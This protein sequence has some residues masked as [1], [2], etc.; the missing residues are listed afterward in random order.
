MPK[1]KTVD[2]HHSAVI[3]YDDELKKILEAFISDLEKRQ[4]FFMGL[5][6]ERSVAQI[7][8]RNIISD[9]ERIIQSTRQYLK[10]YAH[11][12]ELGQA[13]QDEMRDV[14]DITP[15]VSLLAIDKRAL[16]L[17][18]RFDIRK[19]AYF[20]SMG[21]DAAGNG[22]AYARHIT[23]ELLR[24]GNPYRPCFSQSHV[25]P[26]FSETKNTFTSS[27]TILGQDI[28][29]VARTVA[30]NPLQR[31]YLN[32]GV[33][34]YKRTWIAINNRSLT[35][36]SL[37]GIEPRLEVVFP[38]PEVIGYYE[39]KKADHGPD[40]GFNIRF[41]GSSRSAVRREKRSP[42]VIVPSVWA[43]LELA[44]AH[45]L[46]E[47]GKPVPLTSPEADPR[48]R[49]DSRSTV[50]SSASSFGGAGGF[51]F[52]D[53]EACAASPESATSSSLGMSLSTST[54]GRP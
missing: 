50:R 1:L 7:F 19:R 29:S 12:Y 53:R 35:A 30:E 14:I 45:P 26:K 11:F 37:S 20:E 44:L 43:S 13:G 15:K 3:H 31:E 38:E 51:G 32:V 54:L 39:S 8:I 10:S 25:S 6:D 49:V 5:T 22:A 48:A 47:T 36:A 52:F 40:D 16:E 24:M 28:A 46:I 33:C 42:D 2:Q 4:H 41:E 27:G 21:L 18:D 17:F 23:S 9:I 34:Y